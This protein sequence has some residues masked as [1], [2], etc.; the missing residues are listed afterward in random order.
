MDKLIDTSPSNL[1]FENETVAFLS[2]KIAGGEA[3]KFLPTCLDGSG[4][5]S[6][7]SLGIMCGTRVPVAFWPAEEEVATPR[8]SGCTWGR[9]NRLALRPCGSFSLLILGDVPKFEDD[10]MLK[11]KTKLRKSY[12][13][14]T[15]E[16]Q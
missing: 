3:H 7:F 2:F 5:F 8:G 6:L 11:F 1:P 14:N 13:R 16:L 4:R 9:L 10:I 12:Y 15:E